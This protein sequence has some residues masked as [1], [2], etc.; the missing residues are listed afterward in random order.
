MALKKGTTTNPAGRHLPLR[1]LLWWKTTLTFP[2]AR[3][4]IRVENASTSEIQEENG[5]L[6]F[7]TGNLYDAPTHL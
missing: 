4:G 3:L 7:S 1:A 5:T 6:G 2:V